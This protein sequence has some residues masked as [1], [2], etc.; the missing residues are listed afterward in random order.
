[1]A[2]RLAGVA[3]LAAIL[4]VAVS[5]QSNGKPTTFYT[6]IEV[7]HGLDQ[8]FKL[9]YWQ[10]GDLI[11]RDYERNLHTTYLTT[12]D[13]VYIMVNKQNRGVR[14]SP[15][16]KILEGKLIEQYAVWPM[17]NLEQ[18]LKDWEAKLVAEVKMKHGGKQ[19]VALK[20]EY[21]LGDSLDRT[22]TLL[23]DK[24]TRKPIE[25]TWGKNVHVGE[26]L[27]KVEDPSEIQY[28]T[29]VKYLKYSVGDPISPDLF[30]APSVFVD[31]GDWD[32]IVPGRGGTTGADLGGLG[33]GK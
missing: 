26:P 31:K 32:P 16:A 23:V 4:C 27:S 33:D 8:I 10:D 18:F 2:K 28:K 9:S 29:V 20:Y 1:M 21:K 13:G 30:K 6:Q 24:A 11:R 15:K 14:V 7:T 5:A 19:I 3:I 17:G 25:V 12:K 22:A